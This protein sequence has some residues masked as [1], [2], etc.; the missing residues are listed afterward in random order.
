[1]K[2]N[3]YLN[4]KHISKIALKPNTTHVWMQR[5]HK[6]CAQLSIKVHMEFFCKITLFPL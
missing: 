2:S 3:L 6:Y 4:T 5:C 1:M